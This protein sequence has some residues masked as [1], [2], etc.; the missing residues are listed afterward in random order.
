MRFI[1]IMSVVLV[2]LFTTV[3]YDLLEQYFAKN[4]N[5]ESTPKDL[6]ELEKEAIEKTESYHEVVDKVN[7]TEKKVKN[8]RKKTEIKK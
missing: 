5:P 2:I 1:F 6:E 4:K 3:G 8:I 7:E